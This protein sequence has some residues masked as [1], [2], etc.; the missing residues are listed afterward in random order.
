MSFPFFLD[1]LQTL[2]RSRLVLHGLAC[3]APATI[4]DHDAFR[5]PSILG[6]SNQKA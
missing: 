4:S 1:L 6:H 5:K 3:R 2:V